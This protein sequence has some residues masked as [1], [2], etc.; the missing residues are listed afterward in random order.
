M[1]HRG[2]VQQVSHRPSGAHTLPVQSHCIILTNHFTVRLDVCVQSGH[3]FLLRICCRE[4]SRHGG[5]VHETVRN[6][7]DL[8]PDQVPSHLLLFFI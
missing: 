8:L 5:C 3:N 1:L 7:S 4:A 2:Y 6:A